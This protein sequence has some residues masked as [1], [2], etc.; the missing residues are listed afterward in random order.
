MDPER[1]HPAAAVHFAPRVL[2][3]SEEPCDIIHGESL[4]GNGARIKTELYVGIEAGTLHGIVPSLVPG[5][6]HLPCHFGRLRP[7]PGGG[8]DRKAQIVTGAVVDS[9]AESKDRLHIF[10]VYPDDFLGKHILR[11]LIFLE[12]AVRYVIP[13]TVVHV[14]APGVHGDEGAAGGPV[15]E[16]TYHGIVI[17]Y[18]GHRMRAVHWQFQQYAPVSRKRRAVIIIVHPPALRSRGEHHHPSPAAFLAAVI[19]IAFEC[20]HAFR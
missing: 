14:R 19:E 15:V 9:R 18:Y 4:I 12:E 1:S 11:I 17:A 13:A 8:T 16:L 20:Q 2:G 3:H 7:C 6:V 5:N 10:N